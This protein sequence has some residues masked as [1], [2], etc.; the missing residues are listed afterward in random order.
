VHKKT[1][2][3]HIKSF[4]NRKTEEIKRKRF[5]AAVHINPVLVVGIYKNRKSMAP[6]MRKPFPTHQPDRY[7]STRD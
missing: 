4:G 7:R 3:L 5:A 2:A 6:L 1:R